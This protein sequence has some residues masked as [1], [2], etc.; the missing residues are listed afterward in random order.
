MRKGLKKEVCHKTESCDR[1]LFND[2]E[3]YTK[4][5][6]GAICEPGVFGARSPAENDIHKR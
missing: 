5:K 6:Y 1:P 3:T 2:K 4:I